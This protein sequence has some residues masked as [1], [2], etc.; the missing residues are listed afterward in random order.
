MPRRA[1]FALA[2]L[3][4]PPA[5]LCAEDW[6]QWRGARRDGVWTETGLLEK[7]PDKQIKAKWRVPIGPGYS[8]PTVAGGLV[9]VTDRQTQPK[10]V[11]RVH[12]FNEATGKPVWSYSYDCVY[13]NV[14]Y[15]AGPRASV[16]I[17]DGRAFALGSMGHLHVFDAKTGDILWSKDC[18]TLYKIDMP[19]WGIAAAPLIYK[20]LV[21]VEIGGADGA[22]VV[23]FN[24]TTGDEAWKALKDR[25]QYSSPE[26]IKQGGEDVVVIWTGDAI[27]GLAAA[28]GKVHWR[29]PWRP[30][31]M[32]IGCPSPVFHK[33]L[34]LF[35]SFYDGATLLK[36]DQTK[37]AAEK[38]WQRVGQSE[39][40]TDALQGIIS[41]PLIIDDHIYGVDSY[42]ELRCLELKTGDRVWENLTA[43]PKDRWS[44]IHFVK[45]A[46]KIWMFNER[47]ELIIARLTPKGYDE[48]SRAKLIEPT[49]DQ[50][51]LRGGVCW[52][53]PAFANK[54]IFIRNDNEL[55]CASLSAD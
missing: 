2:F 47:G 25:A 51:S 9:Y 15:E 50:L 48:I 31:N 10:Q 33:D 16:L 3:L 19:N 40:N 34:A 46:D 44:T 49:K 42:G 28:T 13:R 32:P 27:C 22:C 21:I 11:E 43:V 26:L 55:V 53:H 38:V 35:V 8:G 23:A 24:K 30:R 7:F 5:L 52:S 12:C 45:N 41:T 18:N 37:P 4:L 17:D 20:N 36:L 39:R 6:P 1:I 14:G 54:H 29:I